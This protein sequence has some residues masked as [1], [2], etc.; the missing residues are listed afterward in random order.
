MRYCSAASHLANPLDSSLRWNDGGGGFTRD[1]VSP[2]I[3]YVAFYHLRI[4]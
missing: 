4:P 3:L 2:E 1:K